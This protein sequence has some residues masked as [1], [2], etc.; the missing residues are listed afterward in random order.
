MDF[1]HSCEAAFGLSNGR[2]RERSLNSVDIFNS[3][4]FDLDFG[5]KSKFIWVKSYVFI[6]F[7]LVPLVSL[8]LY[9]RL[10]R[11]LVSACCN[12]RTLRGRKVSW[13]MEAPG[14]KFHPWRPLDFDWNFL[15]LVCG[16]GL[17]LQKLE[18]ILALGIYIYIY[19]VYI[20]RYIYIDIYRY[21][22]IYIH[23]LEILEIS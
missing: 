5:F 20:Y 2:I 9:T 7:L 21:R 17:N 3:V 15:D 14:A 11:S 4:K 12:S 10:H 18:V 1:I 6:C 13:L 16:G 23:L 8:H 19:T 22:Y